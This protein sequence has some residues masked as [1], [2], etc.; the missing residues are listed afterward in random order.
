MRSIGRND[1]H[2]TDA[3]RPFFRLSFYR[4]RRHP[5][6]EISS[7]MAIS[8]DAWGLSVQFIGDPTTLTS[9]WAWIFQWLSTFTPKTRDREKGR[10]RCWKGGGKPRKNRTIITP[11]RCLLLFTETLRE[12]YRLPNTYSS[13]VILLRSFFFSFEVYQSPSTPIII[14]LLLPLIMMT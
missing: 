12:N 5:D 1:T 13:I 7:P 2:N 10:G 4:I 11:M 14:H 3:G 9:S 8:W 6:P